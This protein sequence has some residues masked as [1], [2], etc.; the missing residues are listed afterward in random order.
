MF[1]AVLMASLLG[2][3][4]RSVGLL[5]NLWL[6]NAIMVGILMRVPDHIR[7]LC[8]IAGA[9][10]LLCGD[11]LTG[12][13]L[14]L[15]FLLNLANLLNITTVYTVLQRLPK[16]IQRLKHVLSMV[17]IVMAAALGAMVGATIGAL[18]LSDRVNEFA[19][20]FMLWWVSEMVHYVA[21]LPI[22]LSSPSWRWLRNDI[23]KHQWSL[24]W[25]DFL[26]GLA[27]VLSCAMVPMIGGAWCHC[28]SCIG[29][30]LVWNILPTFVTAILTFLGTLFVLVFI[31]EGYYQQGIQL[32]V[33]ALFSI[34]IGI[35]V[36]ALAPIMLAIVVARQKELVQQLLYLS[37]HDSLRSA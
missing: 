8:W 33:A 24:Q 34:R 7:W 35:S 10:A 2:I 12:S 21:L 1:V 9:F 28:L 25:F 36:I 31:S 11:L 15:T 5:A 4:T 26:P 29:S 30:A 37:S 32:D 19:A 27:L 14:Y 22:F 6:A 13:D 20:R 18:I 16:D 3:W 17:F 23:K